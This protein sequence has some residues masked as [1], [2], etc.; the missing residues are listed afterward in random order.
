MR[1]LTTVL[2]ALALVVTLGPTAS[3]AGDASPA[4]RRISP[5]QDDDRDRRDGRR[6]DD[7]R[8]R[9]RDRNDDDDRRRHRHRD[10]DDDRRRHRHHYRY[11]DGHHR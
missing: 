3:A 7:D 2:I 6:K 11:Y 8:R 4:D 5:A 10:D 1:K 9:H